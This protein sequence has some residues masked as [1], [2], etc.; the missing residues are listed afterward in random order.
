MRKLIKG[1][2][3]F[4]KHVRPGYRAKFAHLALGQAPDTLFIACS[5]SRVVPNVFASADPGDLFVIR[6]VG[7]FVPPA[8]SQDNSE[9]AALEFAIHKL[10]VSDIIVC[11]HSECGA[12]Q[13]LM[14]GRTRIVAPHLRRWL[15]HGEP[16]L[17]QLRFKQS[18]APALKPHNQLSQLNVLQQ[19]EHLRSYPIVKERLRKG[20]LRLH[21]WWFDLKHADVYAYEDTRQKFVLIDA[22]EAERLLSR[23]K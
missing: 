10:N 5:D 7:N 2:V 13:A 20:K 18:P 4:R 17:K 12:M 16:S 3:T 21:G 15:K 9:A 1:I 11:G 14:K 19:L 6:N 23:I 22:T 8:N